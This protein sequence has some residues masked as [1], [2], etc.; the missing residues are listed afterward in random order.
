M[1]GGE[2]FFNRF[3][4]ETLVRTG[5]FV[6]LA[7]K[8]MR[9]SLLI[10]LLFCVQQAV[11]QDPPEKYSAIWDKVNSMDPGSP[12]IQKELKKLRKENPSDPWIFW[13]SGLTCNPVNGQEEAAAFYQ[14]AIA[15]DSTFPHA[16][17][18][19]AQTF[20][21]ESESDLKERVKL[22]TKA[23]TYDQSL[24]FAFLGRGQAYLQLG[25]YDAALADCDNARSCEDFDLLQ[26]DALQ[27]E[28]LWKQG[29]KEEAFYLLGK[30]DF[31]GGGM[32]G[33]DFELLLAAIYTESGDL[34]NACGCY[35]RAAEPYEMM[36]EEL[37]AEI[38]K[39]LEKCK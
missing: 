21:E 28:V 15:A 14:Q 9:H 7:K 27:L 17:Y 35:R 4:T 18:N 37:P 16:Y 34:E 11:A 5:S 33:T 8:T 20:G 22:F 25:N 29:K 38:Q 12:A 3:L 30:S 1:T 36:G 31:S 39:G 19:L 24:G 26:A 6:T 10:L 32:W 23:V 13:I 2:H